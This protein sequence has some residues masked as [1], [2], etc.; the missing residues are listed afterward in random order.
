MSERRFL[1]LHGWSLRG[2]AMAPLADRLAGH[3]VAECPDLPGHGPGDYPP[4]LDGA[5]AMLGD[6]LR[7]GAPRVLVGW[8]MGALIGWRYLAR[9]PQAPVT[10]MISLD[11]SPRPLPAPGWGFAM[12]A[13]PG[14]LLSRAARY[15]S[16]WQSAAPAIA[17]GIFAPG[18]A[19]RA[20][21]VLPLIA[22]QS[23]PVMAALWLEI[24]AQDLREDMSRITVPQIFIHGAQ[25]QVC[26]AACA[27]WLAQKS[28]AGQGVILPGVGHAPH[29][30]APSDTAAA[31]LTALEA[32]PLR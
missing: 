16:H 28:P 27:M 11:M 20:A 1:L 10:A 29:L 24:L 13:E 18:A 7:D 3:G 25:S 32:L 31:I 15:R 6:L 5:E 19:A 8:S 4:T 12:G 14:P 22:A 2:E 23:G 17:Q 26:P 21:E 9:H 30:E